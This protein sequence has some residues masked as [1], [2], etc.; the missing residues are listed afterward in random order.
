MDPL[1]IA[2]L[3]LASLDA[4]FKVGSK[5]AS[6]IAD[7]NAFDSVSLDGGTVPMQQHGWT[8]SGVIGLSSLAWYLG[9]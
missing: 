5:T 8:H 3:T 7:A 6:M 9:R 1:S 4:L 2:G